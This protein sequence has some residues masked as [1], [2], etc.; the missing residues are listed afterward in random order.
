MGKFDRLVLGLSDWV[1]LGLVWLGLLWVGLDLLGFDLTCDG[2]GWI[3]FR[4]VG[5]GWIALER[6]GLGWDGVRCGIMT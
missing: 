1:G 2:S 6:V 4:F 5:L 3:G